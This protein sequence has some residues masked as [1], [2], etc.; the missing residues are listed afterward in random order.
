MYEQVAAEYVLDDDVARVLRRS[1]PWAL[2]AIAERLLEAADRGLW[3][4]ARAAE[5]LDAL[6]ERLPGGSRASSRRPARVTAAVSRSRR[7]VG[8]DGLRRGAAGVRRRPA[9]GGV[10]VRG[11]RGTAKTTA[12]AALAPLLP[13]VD[14][15][16]GCRVRVR[17]RPSRARVSRRPAR[18]RTRPA[19]RGRRRSS[20]CRSAP[21]PTGVRRHARPRARAPRG[22]ARRSS[23]GCWRRA[24][25]GILYVDE[26]NLLPDHL[27]DV[28]LDAAAL[29]RQP[30]R[31]RR[32]L[33]PR[34]PARFLLVGTMNPEEG[35]LRPQLLDRFGLARRG[36]RAAR[37]GACGRRSCAAGWP[38]T[39]TRPRSPRG[40]AA[41]R[42]RAGGRGSAPR[43]S[44]WR[45][46]ACPTRELLL[47]AGACARLG[48][49]GLR[50]D[51]VCAR[52]AAALAA[53]DGARRGRRRR[54][55]PRRAARARAPPPAR[56]ARRARAR[57]RSELDEACATPSPTA[58][59]TTVP[60]R[61][62]RRSGQR[63]RPPTRGRRRAATAADA[64]QGDGA[65]ER[66]AASAGPTRGR[67]GGPERPAAAG[68]P[69][70]SPRVAVG[71]RR[72]AAGR[73][74]RRPARAEA[75]GSTP[76][77]TDGA[78]STA[79]VA[80]RRAAARR[81]AARHRPGALAPRGPARA[82]ARRARG[83]PG[84]ASCV[85]ASAAR[86]AR[87]AGWRAVKGALLALLRRRLPAARPGRAGH[88]PRR[89][90]RVVLLADRRALERAAARARAT[91]PT[92]GRTP[93]AAGLARAAELIAASARRDPDAPR[94]SRSSSPT[95]G[96]AG[97]P[98]ARRR[99]DAARTLAAAADRLVV[100][101]AEE[102]PVRLGL[103]AALAEP[104]A[105]E[106][107]RL[108][109]AQPEGVA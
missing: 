26:V 79:P 49:D 109:R 108:A 90:P 9:V 39:P 68:A 67:S 32:P 13:A 19:R 48:V 56:P 77:G 65:A 70:R 84:R 106:L 16:D 20:S 43:A 45:A 89:R 40:S 38:S 44:G 29:G 63:P 15:V 72:G 95:A 57:R 50:A 83:Q 27:V 102:G 30:R 8:Q 14:V 86:W 12:V 54:R 18:R 51:I 59:R 3:E 103:A 46:C 10:L 58:A 62:P 107:L 52:A 60:S 41:E 37:P 1:N 17:T 64:A 7:I 94:R 92:G 96:Q 66:G 76:P 55:P 25:R 22:R 78:G 4:H 33:A 2:R 101:D 21:P 34:T 93:L 42:A 6:R 71:S 104:P 74:P 85:D 36:A 88:L 98:A 73:S 69:H 28:L 87:A 105:G 35:E 47:I 31:A 11:E 61:R 82:R 75:A 24:H 91:L 23:P 5:T 100:F 80:A 99:C 81:R 97:R 53:L